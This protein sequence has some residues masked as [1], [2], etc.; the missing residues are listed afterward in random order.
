MQAWLNQCAQSAPYFT[1]VFRS[2][3]TLDG[4]HVTVEFNTNHGFPV[5]LA[6]TF[7]QVAQTIEFLQR[8]ML[9][10]QSD[11]RPKLS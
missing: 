1:G 3:D 2:G 5:H 6:M 7:D 9:L 10:A 11:E 8:E 4:K